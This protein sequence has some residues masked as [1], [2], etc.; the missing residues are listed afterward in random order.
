MNQDLGT[1]VSTV[2]AEEK[3]PGLLTRMINVF[4]N[5]QSTFSAI[6]DKPDWI[7]PA[8]IFA[9]V[10]GVIGYIQV[11]DPGLVKAKQQMVEEMMAKFNLSA[12][13]VA[14]AQETNQ[15]RE[16]ITA[17][18]GAFLMPLIFTVFIGGAI[19]LL[20]TNVVFGAKVRYVAMLGVTSYTLLITALGALVKL[21]IMIAKSDLMVHFSLALFLPMEMTKTFLYRFLMM[22][23]DIFNIWTIIVLSMGVAIVAS[24]PTK[25]IWPIVAALNVVF[26]LGSAALMSMFS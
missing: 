15:A 7:V 10:M 5:P 13:Q 9:L 25:K 14:A 11:T 2:V 21:P 1:P 12:E 22:A 6:K 19:W 3:R 17:P 23:T 26:C 4:F 24:L 20:V 18:L 16:R 8:L